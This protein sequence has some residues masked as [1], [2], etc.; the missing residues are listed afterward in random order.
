MILRTS[1]SCITRARLVR[2]KRVSGF[3]RQIRTLMFLAPAVLMATV[4]LVVGGASG[5]SQSEPAAGADVSYD[6]PAAS[7]IAEPLQPGPPPHAWRTDALVARTHEASI[8]VHQ[9]T[10]S[11]KMFTLLYSVELTAES[12]RTADVV[13]HAELISYPTGQSGDAVAHK[14]LHRAPGVSLGGL[15]FELSGTPDYLSLQI[16]ALTIEDFA[17]RTQRMLVGPWQIPLLRK[18]SNDPQVSGFRF[19]SWTGRRY[20]DAD[21]VKS[22]E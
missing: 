4:S 13:P 21:R 14:V 7:Q 9:F 22:F 18:R 2:A 10:M 1:L 8:T 16:D 15:S 3:V 12:A 5:C 17:S 11:E 6:Y 19:G 20:S